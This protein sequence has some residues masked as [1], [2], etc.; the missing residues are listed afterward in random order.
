MGAIFRRY[1]LIHVIKA[2]ET[3]EDVVVDLLGKEYGFD[4]DNMAGYINELS[5]ENDLSKLDAGDVITLTR[6]RKIN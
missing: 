3:I 2:G 6:Y 4:M 1:Y 5:R